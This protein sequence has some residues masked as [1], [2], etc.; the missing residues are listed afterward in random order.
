VTKT[1]FGVFIIER[2]YLKMNND[3]DS[4]SERLNAICPLLVQFA[5]VADTGQVTKAANRTGTPQ[6]TVT[7]HLAR[8]ESILG[9]RLF[10]RVPGGVELTADG[11]LMVE[12]IRK[13]LEN[14]SDALQQLRAEEHQ[15]EI[16]LGFLPSLGDE[17]IPSLLRAMSTNG[18][19]VGLSLVQD[20]ADELLRKLRGEQL[21]M[22]LTS[23]PPQDADITTATLAR[24]P[25]VLAVPNSHPLASRDAIELSLAASD[26]FLALQPDNLMRKVTN[27]L[28]EAAGFEP[29]I[30]FEGTGISTLRGMIAAGLGVAVLP[31]AATPP[32]S[33]TELTLTDADAS[34]EIALAWRSNTIWS[35]E[36]AEFKDYVIAEFRKHVT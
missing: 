3:E 9:L 30:A 12:P 10:K 33:L 7:R 13:A 19:R 34:R 2:L 4:V 24:Q 28:C 8:M 22:C 26:T 1:H 29:R 18:P 17:A 15:R 21:D 32:G 27:A 31:A 35:E 11:Q 5:A 25:L 14:V 16:T 36:A 20:S 23:P 6:P